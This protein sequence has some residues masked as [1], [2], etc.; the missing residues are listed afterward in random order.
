MTP[1]QFK[2]HYSL[3]IPVLDDEHWELICTM[4]MVYDAGQLGDLAGV[5]TNSSRLLKQLSAHIVNEE[6]YLTSIQYPYLDYHKSCHI[7]L[8]RKM[9]DIVREL[10]E[11]NRHHR[12]LQNDLYTVFVHHVD[13]VDLQVGKYVESKALIA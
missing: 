6:R 7:E 12:D 3:N 13:S 5:V 2:A 11:G 4:N 1:D 8:V 10:N 9:V